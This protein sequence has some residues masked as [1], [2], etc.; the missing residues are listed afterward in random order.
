M[1]KTKTWI[2]IFGSLL[3]LCAGLSLW[4]FLKPTGGNVANVYLDGKCVHSVDLSAVTENYEFTVSS[5]RGMNVIRVE[6]GYISVV[7]ADCPDKVC[8]HSGRISDSAAPICCLPHRLV[9]KIEKEMKA[10]DDVPDAVS[11]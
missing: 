1:I 9:I 5:D 10:G 6:K 8:I 11:K 7:D 3:A 2:I 4:I